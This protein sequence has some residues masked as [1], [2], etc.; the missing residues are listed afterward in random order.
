MVSLPLRFVPIVPSL[1]VYLNS[2]EQYETTDWTFN[3]ATNKIDV[4]SAM[5]ARSGDLL[6]TRYAHYSG[7]APILSGDFIAANATGGFTNTPYNVALPTHIVGDLL[8]VAVNTFVAI[9]VSAGWSQRINQSIPG[10]GNL[11]VS[12]LRVFTKTAVAAEPNPT[13]T[14][15]GTSWFAGASGAY[16]GVSYAEIGLG[17]SAAATASHA[18]LGV[19]GS[20]RIVHFWAM[21]APRD[22]TMVASTKR[23]YVSAGN[24]VSV[25]FG[26]R[27]GAGDPDTATTAAAG[28]WGGVTMRLAG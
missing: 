21:T 4:L 15:S 26:D 2:I 6:E 18:T 11:G 20:G 5:D 13:F 25:A 24:A 27:I 14:P 8:T 7:L 28:S 23:N 10:D 19:T 17:N 12:Y 22:P 1:H 16:R 9:T 3:P